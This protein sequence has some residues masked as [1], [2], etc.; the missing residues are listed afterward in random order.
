M[1]ILLGEN[2]YEIFSKT[3]T[4]WLFEWNRLPYDIQLMWVDR[5]SRINDL[6]VHFD[7]NID[8]V[9]HGNIIYYCWD[10]IAS[11]PDWGTFP[12]EDQTFFDRMADEINSYYGFNFTINQSSEEFSV[13]SEYVM[14][15]SNAKA[16][17]IDKNSN[18]EVKVEING[19]ESD[20]VTLKSFKEMVVNNE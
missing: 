9:F 3:I 17:I 16:K 7:R 4:C 13:G 14:K 2:L 20:Y 6:A 11:R 5:A 18:D 8:E 1:N 10:N 15:R 12:I 19:C